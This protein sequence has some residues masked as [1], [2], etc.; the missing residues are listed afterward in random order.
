MPDLVLSAAG[1]IAPVTTTTA[2]VPAPV[3]AG[4]VTPPTTPMRID[5]DGFRLREAMKQ[6][7]MQL[8][9]RRMHEKAVSFAN[10]GHINIVVPPT[11][12][13]TPPIASAFLGD[14][15][16]AEITPLLPSANRAVRRAFPAGMPVNVSMDVRA[17]SSKESDRRIVAIL[18]DTSTSVAREAERI[19]S[20]V[21]WVIDSAVSPQ[22]TNGWFF[23]FVVVSFNH[24]ASVLMHVRD[25]IPRVDEIEAV[26]ANLKFSGGT[27]VKSAIDK[28]Y[29][30]LQRGDGGPHDTD[31][32]TVFFATDGEDNADLSRVF[33]DE[34]GRGICADT[35]LPRL[36]RD[37][38]VVFHG[39]GI[40]SASVNKDFLK[41]LTATAGRGSFQVVEW[42]SMQMMADGFAKLMC[43]TIP[44][45]ATL[46]WYSTDV[47]NN[48]RRLIRETGIAIREDVVM[49]QLC[50]TVPHGTRLSVE[51]THPSGCYDF[52][53]CINV[54]VD[55][56]DDDD[57]PTPSSSTISLGGM[58]GRVVSLML[59]RVMADYSAHKARVLCGVGGAVSANAKRAC[60]ASIQKK[61]DDVVAAAR[62][63]FGE[64]PEF[65]AFLETVEDEQRCLDASSSWSSQNVAEQASQ[66]VADE[67]QHAF[68]CSMSYEGA[69]EASQKASEK[70]RIDAIDHP[71]QSW[72]EVEEDC[73]Q[74]QQQ[75]DSQE[76]TDE[77][78]PSTPA[79]AEGEE[80]EE[81]GVAAK[82]HK[83]S[84]AV[85]PPPP[86]SASWSRWGIIPT[87]HTQKKDS[88]MSVAEGDDDEVVPSSI[89][90]D[91]GLSPMGDKD[92]D[93]AK[94]AAE[95]SSLTEGRSSTGYHRME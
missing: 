71:W 82:R 59:G 8:R 39:M 3:E 43:V 41:W 13:P 69:L 34:P 67:S 85:P 46:R 84:P 61:L 56:R 9:N 75:Q 58:D 49:N 62:G 17:R 35:A 11:R 22:Y 25:R 37:K 91:P 31:E 93:D 14:M 54:P 21:R 76:T 94:C 81:D 90:N 63:L 80:G 15:M 29:E 28:L 32:M 4:Y 83:P 66:A 60:V 5:I 55:D 70:R 86:L 38:W 16:S 50:T 23:S 53:L 88:M 6:H 68:S 65:A 1:I 12:P 45:E 78:P 7:D 57:G 52:D 36:H 79:P 64:T 48:V 40:G 33:D 77:R 72:Q 47:A 51:L 89:P 20:L 87:F 24:K 95:V 92:G 30:E 42:P 74:Q 18:I 73:G 2:T 27:N 19:K 10:N 26:L 44:G